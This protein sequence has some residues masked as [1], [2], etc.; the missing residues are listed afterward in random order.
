MG[1]TLQSLRFQ[2]HTR[3]TAWRFNSSYTAGVGAPYGR[4]CLHE[5]TETKGFLEQGAEGN[6][7]E[8][9]CVENEPFRSC[10]LCVARQM[11]SA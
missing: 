1:F 9:E 10:I 8:T 2:L 5:E 11:L 3:C 7:E 6:K 4:E